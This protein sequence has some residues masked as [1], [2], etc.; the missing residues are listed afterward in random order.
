MYGLFFKLEKWRS[1]E[2]NGNISK[3]MEL[4]ENC[5]NLVFCFS[6][7]GSRAGQKALQSLRQRCILHNHETA[8]LF[9]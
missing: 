1:K 4:T 6:T 8:F 9:I 3:I 5:T 7:S 2:E